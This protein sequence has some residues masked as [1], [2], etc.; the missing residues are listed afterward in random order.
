MDGDKSGIVLHWK[1][2]TER[3][4]VFMC[5]C[6]N[7]HDQQCQAWVLY[8][9][10]WNLILGLELCFIPYSFTSLPPDPAVVVCSALFCVNRRVMW[11]L[12]DPVPWRFWA[13]SSQLQPCDVQKVRLACFEICDRCLRCFVAVNFIASA[14]FQMTFHRL[15]TCIAPDAIWFEWNPFWINHF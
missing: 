9:C 11:S 14:T 4:C 6:G 3:E 12:S 13:Q 7:T 10:T 8:C 5:N 15:P 1:T 2:G